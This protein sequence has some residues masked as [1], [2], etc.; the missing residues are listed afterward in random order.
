MSLAGT[1]KTVLQIINEVE[2]R[3]GL[4]PSSSITSS[5][6][7]VLYLQLLN[8]VLEEID[9]YS[10]WQEQYVEYTVSAS[11]GSTSFA[12][13]TNDQIKRIEEVSFGD[14]V[15]PLYWPGRDQVRLLNRTQSSAKGG[16]PRHVAIIGTV[17]GGN[18]Q[19]KVWP[20]PTTAVASGNY[21]VAAYTL[22]ENFT[23]A[24]GASTPKYSA[25]LLIKG[26]YAYALLEQE[27]GMMSSTAKNAFQDYYN[28]LREVHN[29]YTNDSESE[30]KIQP[31]YVN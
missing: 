30:L 28:Q 7:S 31:W 21:K 8:E 3:L 16:N 17:S 10:D 19:F 5:R 12:L 15:A 26:L 14:Q 20:A 4:T 29:R 13:G 1:R 11:A 9:N 27:D 23:S 22:T 6:L 18:P 2:R 24:D 25:N